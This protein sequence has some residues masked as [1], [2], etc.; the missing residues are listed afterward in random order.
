MTLQG[1]FD[2]AAAGGAG[3]GL[4]EE[5]TAETVRADAVRQMTPN[6]SQGGAWGGLWNAVGGVLS[7]VSDTELARYQAKRAYPEGPAAPASAGQPNKASK[8]GGMLLVGGAV[9]LAAV[10][11]MLA[12]K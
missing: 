11:Y 4:G 2:A 5:T 9:V 3:V 12:R 8:G 1:V 7:K 6:N 10:V